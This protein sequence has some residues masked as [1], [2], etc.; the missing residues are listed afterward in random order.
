MLKMY[1][2]R[3]VYSFIS[4]LTQFYFQTPI[5]FNLNS[6]FQRTNILVYL[7]QNKDNILHLLFHK[8]LTL[9]IFEIADFLTLKMG[10]VKS[11]DCS[12]TV[13]T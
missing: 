3:H 4:G 13:D 9:S 2:A 11:S 7:H 12:N 8:S 5:L 6:L 1:H 10:H